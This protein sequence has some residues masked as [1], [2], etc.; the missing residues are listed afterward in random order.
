MRPQGVLSCLP[1]ANEFD[2]PLS[3]RRVVETG[4][5]TRFVTR[6]TARTSGQTSLELT[7]L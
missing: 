6:E 1:A 2:H 3:D 4:D 7:G 5:S